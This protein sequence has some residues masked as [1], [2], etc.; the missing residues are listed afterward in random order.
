MRVLWLV[1]SNLQQHPGGGTT[2]IL[3]TTVSLRRRGITVDLATAL[4]LRP[5]PQGENARQKRSQGSLGLLD[6][7]PGDRYVVSALFRATLAS[8]SSMNAANRTDI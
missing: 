2:Q 1:R 3:Q 7:L 5:A 6:A 8:P 4:P